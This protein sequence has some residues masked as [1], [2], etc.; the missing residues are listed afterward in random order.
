MVPHNSSPN[1]CHMSTDQL[2]QDTLSADNHR[3]GRFD[4]PIALT[5]PAGVSVERDREWGGVVAPSTAVYS[6]GDGPA[7]RT[8]LDIFF[9]T[10]DDY[11][12]AIALNDGVVALTYLELLG[13][14]E[15]VALTMR[16]EGIGTG[17]RVGIRVESGTVE[18]YIAILAVL[19]RGAAYVPVDYDEP[20]E[21]ARLV[22]EEARVSAVVETGLHVRIMADAPPHGEDRPPAGDDDAWIIFTS[23]STGKPKGVAISHRSAAAF[24][25]AESSVFCVDAPLGP[26]DRVM[27]GLSIGFDASCEEMWLAWRYG[28]CLVPAPRDVVRSGED[29]GPWLAEH[30]ITVVSTVPTLA[31]LWPEESLENVRLLIFGGEACP[32]ELAAR[33]TTA[34]REVWNT[35]GP[36]EATVVSC[37]AEID[38]STPV[39]IGLP[40]P[41]WQLAVVDTDDQPVAWG[42][43]GELVIGGVG[44]GRYLDPEKDSEKYAPMK[45]LGWPR[46]Y[47]SG[48][49]VRAEPEGLVFVG[50]AD[51]QV[52]LAGQRVELGE[53]DDALSQLANVA[54]GA[55]A[56]QKS[57]DGNGILAG[58][59]VPAPD[60]TVDLAE[61]R[62][63]LSDKLPGRLVP[64][65]AVVDELPM[66]TSGKVDRKALPWPLP[67]TRV[68][69]R[70]ERS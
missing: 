33:L 50:R 54:A 18:L 7:P 42:E 1:A 28:A 37:A 65:L 2:A 68:Q 15:S 27:A 70:Q 20:E 13:R 38:G 40:L 26:N 21:R 16:A 35:Y 51:D 49:V 58:Y 3:D 39:R 6:G 56:V 23:G 31:A 62:T 59:L 5:A 45:T 44:L 67:L 29:L 4:E 22:W 48:D 61:A 17:D 63:Q 9:R 66:K 34:G 52:K 24:V 60:K 47:R 11:P 64:A 12:D 69:P 32:P 25:D 10:V 46:A 41:G 36:T 19:V 30:D 53:V 43:E 8:L 55:S 57:P 14:I